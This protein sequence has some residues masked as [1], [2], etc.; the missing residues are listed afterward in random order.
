[1]IIA[2]I[3]VVIIVHDNRR[4]N[5]HDNRHDNC[6]D[7]RHD[8]RRDNRHDNCHDNRRDNRHDN[9]GLATCFY[10]CKELYFNY[11]TIPL[12][13]YFATFWTKNFSTSYKPSYNSTI[14]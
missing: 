12:Y 8:N 11:S 14:L 7:N 10:H 6:C 5:R 13:F 3:I 2:I 4:D 1:M 9:R